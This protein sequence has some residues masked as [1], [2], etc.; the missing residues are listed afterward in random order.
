LAKHRRS[1]RTGQSHGI[2]GFVGWAEY[3][4]ELSEFLP[5]LQAAQWT[6]VGRHCVWGNGELRVEIVDHL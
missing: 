1:S 3:Q 4:G 2:G 6:G 5:I